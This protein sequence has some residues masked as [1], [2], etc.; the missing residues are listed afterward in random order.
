MS[1]TDD[2]L[3]ALEADIRHLKDRQEILDVIHT[4]SRG[5]D[6]FDVE[7]VGAA[8]HEDGFDDHGTWAR[9]PAKEYPEF[10]NKVHDGGS[11]L[12]LHN[13]GTH[14]CEIDGDVAHAETYV[15]G[16]M[17]NK[18]GVTCRLLNGRYLDRLER[19]DGK[20]RIALRRCTVDVV[21]VGDSAIMQ[22]EPFK[23]FGMIKSARDKSDPT[24]ARPLTME[25][26][27]ET[28]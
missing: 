15:M 6:R 14:T 23:A 1:T 20:W 7:E 26:P 4:L 21:L 24:Y 28:W 27:V 18:D 16:A 2:R 22:S 13:L 12:S 25:T 9:T 10:I 19:R 5:T 17:L 8:F 11:I 3:A